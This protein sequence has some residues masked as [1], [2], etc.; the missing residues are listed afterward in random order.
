M[1]KFPKK[2]RTPKGAGRCFAEEKSAAGI[3]SGSDQAYKDLPPA[4]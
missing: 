2:N 4:H 3:N 1:D